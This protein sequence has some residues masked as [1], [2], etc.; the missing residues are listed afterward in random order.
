MTVDEVEKSLRLQKVF[1]VTISGINIIFVR[2]IFLL[3]LYFEDIQGGNSYRPI[4]YIMCM[5]VL[6]MILRVQ[7]EFCRELYT[8]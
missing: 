7:S 2:Y 4:L 5:T 1:E 8:V 3:L 6:R